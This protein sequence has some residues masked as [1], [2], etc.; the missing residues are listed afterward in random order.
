LADQR[1]TV[2]FSTQFEQAGAP[3][4]WIVGIKKKTTSVEAI[5]SED[6]P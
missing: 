2:G 1:R 6:L 5:E 4:G 3:A